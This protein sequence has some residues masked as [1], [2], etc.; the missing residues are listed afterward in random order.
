MPEPA[1]VPSLDPNSSSDYNTFMVNIGPNH[2]G[3]QLVFLKLGGSLIT[4]KH[5]ARSPRREVINRIAR[6]IATSLHKNPRLQIILGH[7]SGS[8]GHISGKKYGTLNGVHAPEEWRG[9]AEVRYDASLLNRIVLDSLMKAGVSALAFPPSAAVITQERKIITWDLEPLRSALRKGLLPVV[10]G[11]V[12]F[13]TDRGGTILSTEDLF[14]HLALQFKPE[15]ILLAGK[16]PGVWEDYPDCTSL[17]KEITPADLP[18]LQEIIHQSGAPDVTGGME[19]KVKKMLQLSD[20]LPTLETVI[21]SGEAPESIQ[22][23]LGG[24]TK[25]TILHG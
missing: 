7:G 2:S 25:G 10:Y 12:V 8:F 13:D 20:K 18:T 6:E 14:F 24:D 1:L 22:S 5:T 3:D 23:I 16:D 19:A 17:L 15:R 9:F 11:D 4:N 21:F